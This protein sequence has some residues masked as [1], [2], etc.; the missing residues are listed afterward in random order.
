MISWHA[1]GAYAQFPGARNASIHRVCLIQGHHACLLVAHCCDL[2]VQCNCNIL[3]SL[4]DDALNKL[5]LVNI[6]LNDVTPFITKLLFTLCDSC[7]DKQNSVCG[8]LS[9]MNSTENIAMFSLAQKEC[10]IQVIYL[11]YELQVYFP[12][13]HKAKTVERQRNAGVT[14]SYKCLSNQVNIDNISPI[15]HSSNARLGACRQE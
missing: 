6:S 14:N 11:V 5:D 4:D 7:N 2:V 15:Y 13:S 10:Y 9:I 12:S 3:P 1:I 8:V